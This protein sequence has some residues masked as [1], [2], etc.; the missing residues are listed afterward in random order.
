M[1]KRPIVELLINNAA[2]NNDTDKK[3][4]ATLISGNKVMC[5]PCT[6]IQKNKLFGCNICTLHAE[7]NAI[8]SYFGRS[9]YYNKNTNKVFLPKKNNK[10]DLIVIR[11]NKNNDLCNSRPC[12]NCLDMMKMVGI[13]KVYYSID[14]NIICENVKDMV[15]IQ[16]SKVVKD[17]NNVFIN[18]NSLDEYY[19]HLLKKN[20]PDKINYN[21]LNNFLKYNFNLL[22]NFTF[23]IK[24]N[25]ISI[26]NKEFSLKSIIIF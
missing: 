26:K 16:S 12:F 3:L 18:F 5:K 9:F 23:E 13:R 4:S 14:N 21:S 20:F 10:L 19:I 2:K 17:I 25:I 7:A 6:N 22:S 1:I 8:I 24:N 11:I 15:S